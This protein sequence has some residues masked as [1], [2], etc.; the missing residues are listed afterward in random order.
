MGDQ[1][2]VRQEKTDKLTTSF[3]SVP[4]AV[5]SREG[6]SVTIEDP[7]GTQYKAEL[8]MNKNEK[9]TSGR[10]PNQRAPLEGDIITQTRPKRQIK[11]PEKFKDFIVE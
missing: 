9:L 4:F 11:L 8:V 1:V 10:K 6:N 7:G 2:L 3:K 5:V